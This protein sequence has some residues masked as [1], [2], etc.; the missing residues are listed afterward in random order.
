[1][2]KAAIHKVRLD[3]HTELLSKEDHS[4]LW[5]IKEKKIKNQLTLKWKLLTL[6]LRLYHAKNKKCQLSN[7]LAKEWGCVLPVL[8]FTPS[9]SKSQNITQA[10]HFPGTDLAETTF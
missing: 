4:Q 3:C 7:Y 10:K 5:C 8:Y 1:M 9:S 2:Y 6:G